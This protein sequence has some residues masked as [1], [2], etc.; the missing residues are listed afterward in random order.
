MT[1]KQLFTSINNLCKELDN[2]YNIN[3]GGC[4][5]VAAVIAEQLE[6]HNIFYTLIHYDK[7]SCHYAIRVNDRIL[8]RCDYNFR[9]IVFDEYLPSD[10]IFFTY[11]N[12]SWNK[13]YNKKW[14]LIVKTKIKSI[15][16]KY[17]NSRT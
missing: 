4:C 12:E 17:E 10:T 1:K 5:F 15:F 7:Y 14:N 2:K 8:N 13:M 16:K 11:Y 3:C 6:K 9:E